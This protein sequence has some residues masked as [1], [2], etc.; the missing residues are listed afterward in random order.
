[1]ARFVFLRERYLQ[2]ISLLLLVVLAFPTILKK[3]LNLK[4]FLSPKKFC[5]I[6]GK[7]GREEKK[8]RAFQ[9]ILLLFE[10]KRRSKNDVS[11]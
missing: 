7:K 4:I 11:S 3:I 9:E 2:G 5:L 10:Y 8:L 6:R 1:M